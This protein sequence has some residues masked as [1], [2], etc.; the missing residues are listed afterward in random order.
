MADQNPPVVQYDGLQKGTF[1]TWL[2]L[3]IG[4]WVALIWAGMVSLPM[5]GVGFG[6]LGFGLV[7]GW[8]L[9]PLWGSVW[10]R[11]GLSR[12]FG[13][14]QSASWLTLRPSDDPLTQE[15]YAVADRLG[16]PA[17]PLVGVMDACNA[18]AM[19]SR[20][21]KSLVVI[22]QP[23]IDSL[24]RDELR[25][26]IGHELGHIANNDMRRMV[27][28][29][30]F[31][32]ALTWYLGFSYH[33]QHGARWLLSW[34]SELYVLRLSRS[35]EYWAD[36]IGAAVTSPAAMISALE[37]IHNVDTFTDYEKRNLRV[38][39]RGRAGTSMLSTHPTLEQRCAALNSGS[40]IGL[41]PLLAGAMV[42]QDIEA[43]PLLSD[44]TPDGLVPPAPVER[45][46]EPGIRLD[47]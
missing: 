41:L 39:F 25:A 14:A 4:S 31:Q 35:R 44:E 3:V 26:I 18:Y 22:G 10:G 11:V 16:M 38:M 46:L 43:P 2:G 32:N 5:A 40:H 1:G 47:S 34:A 29:R 36:A 30:S 45:Q 33:L 15:V 37:K 20:P 23:L 24:S 21:D 8:L 42:T 9:V 19:G 13:S 27:Y 7:G 17:R 12:S 28:A 6:V